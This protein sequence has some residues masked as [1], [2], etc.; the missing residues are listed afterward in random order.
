MSADEMTIASMP[1]AIASIANEVVE[2]EGGLNRDDGLHRRSP[3][4]RG[5]EL[6]HASP[7]A[8]TSDA[9]ADQLSN[10]TASTTWT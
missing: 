2:N 1:E 5:A 6:C 7:A 8:I 4:G 3:H 10:S 9:I